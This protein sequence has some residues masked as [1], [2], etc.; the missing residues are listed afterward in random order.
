MILKIKKRACKIN[1]RNPVKILFLDEDNRVKRAARIIKRQKIA[2]PLFLNEKV[3]IEKKIN[4][5]RLMLKQDK[6]DAVISGA[7]HSSILAILLSFD[8][9][10]KNIN[11]VSGSFLM[12]SPDK[13]K[14]LLFADCAAQP[15][16]SPR[17]LAEI[18]LLSAETFELITIKKPRIALLSY[19]THG[20]GKGKSLQKVSKALRILKKKYPKL[21][22]KGEIQAD[23]ALNAVIAKRKGIKSINA[24]VLIFPNLDAANIG[25]KLVEQLGGWQAIGPVLQGLSKQVNDLSRGC[26]VEDIVALA[27]ITVLQVNE[28][29]KNKKIERR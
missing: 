25:Y 26:K 11:H 16:P 1:K 12:I 5:A 20:S 21:I 3:N 23:A 9:M 24:N 6:V 18:A 28:Q 22:M 10:R 13:K 15:D 27:A 17:Q 7:S 2:K 29:R 4:L 8:F 14:V 19:S